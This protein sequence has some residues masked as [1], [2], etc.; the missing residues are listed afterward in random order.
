MA[1]KEVEDQESSK[2]QDLTILF[3]GGHLTPAIATIE[4][5]QK[6]YPEIKLV[7]VGREYSQQ[8][9]EQLAKERETCE[10]LGIPFHSLQAA[11]FHRSAWW[12]NI[13]ELPQLLPSF[14]QAYQIIKNENIDLFISFGGYLAVPVAVVAKLLGKKVV[15][16]EQTKSTGLANELIALI[17]DKVAISYHESLSHFPAHKT[18]ITGNPIRERLLHQY[19]RPPKWYNNSSKPILYITGGSQGSQTINN[20]VGQIL[21]KLTDKFSVIHQVGRSPNQR[22]LYNML[23]QI[24]NLSSSQKERYFPREWLDEQEVSWILQNAVLAISRSGANTTLEMTIHALPSIFIPLPFAYNNEQWK[25]A[26][27]LVQ[28]GAAVLLEQ[29]DLT[30]QSLWSTVKQ[31]SANRAHMSRR[32][33]KL[34]D[35]LNI[36]GAKNLAELA[37]SLLP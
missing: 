2:R 12:R 10:Q 25:N 11:K 28:A 5:L 1:K 7:F 22:Y 18:V 14:W 3:S 36:D 13:Y 29:K 21:D 35:E 15:T 17:A 8:Q 31:A 30:P 26:Q 32:A 27:E 19:K 24:Q 33:Q 4:Y 23:D 20:V 9:E 37:L 16:H 6:N 34:R